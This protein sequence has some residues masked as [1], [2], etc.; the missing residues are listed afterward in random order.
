VSFR[1]RRALAV[2]WKDGLDLSRNRALLASMAIFPM[3]LSLVPVG[4]VFAY[5]HQP[6]DPSLTEMAR[7]YDPHVSAHGAVRFMIDKLLTDWFGL[8]LMMPVFVPILISSQSVASEK[9]RRTLEPLLASPVTA[10]ELLVGKS[11]AAVV[12][13]LAITWLAFALFCA[14]ID[15]VS[16][17]LL[18]VWLMPNGMWLF[19]LVC[20]APPFAF[21]G[22]GIAV[23]IS[24]RVGESRLA[25]QL[26]A[27]FVLPMIGLVVGQLGGWLAAGV[28]YYALEG[29]VVLA[30]D[31]LL[32]WASVRL[33][34]RERLLTRWS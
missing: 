26:S 29:L 1:L 11:V 16:T 23:L 18:H 20:I 25:Q 5:A 9:E 8:F 19:G 4:V 7:Y 6:N 17:R 27:L 3:V 21:F 12:P 24:A 32:V 2:A 31:A 13:S 22:N 28:R 10:L 33:F 34:D 30:L 15:L 14:G